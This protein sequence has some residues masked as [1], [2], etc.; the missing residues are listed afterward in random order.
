MPIIGELGRGTLARGAGS[1]DEENRFT[2]VATQFSRLASDLWKTK[3]QL[4]VLM[5]LVAWSSRERTRTRRSGR[6]SVACE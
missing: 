5:R 1:E 3:L 2:T 6:G 4:E